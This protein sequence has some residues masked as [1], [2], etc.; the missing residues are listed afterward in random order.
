MLIAIHGAKTHNLLH[1]ASNGP[2]CIETIAHALG[3]LN[4]WTGHTSRPYT[5][6]EHSVRVA[7]LVPPHLR[8]HALL[9]DAAEAFIGDISTPMREMIGAA[10][11]REIEAR[12]LTWIFQSFGL[13]PA[14]WAD[15]AILHADRVM[16]STEARDFMGQ[17][18]TQ[19]GYPEPLA[20]IIGEAPD[21]AAACFL[22]AF[23]EWRA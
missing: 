13:E 23:H 10:R 17:D 19:W 16:L 14:T 8:L 4:R 2:A 21:N 7:L 15:Q 9:H 20:A 3:N 6:A 5:V 11:V 18:A 1:P 22:K 12:H